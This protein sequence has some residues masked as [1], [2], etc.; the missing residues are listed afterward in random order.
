[1]LLS[2]QTWMSGSPDSAPPLWRAL[3][4]QADK[5]SDQK[6]GLVHGSQSTRPNHAFDSSACMM[7]EGADGGC[8]AYSYAC[9]GVADCHLG[10]LSLTPRR[11]PLILKMQ[12]GAQRSPPHRLA[13]WRRNPATLPSC[14]QSIVSGAGGAAPRPLWC[15]SSPSWSV[16]SFSPGPRHLTTL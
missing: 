14:I 2:H 11:C 5:K 16:Q 15:T 4:P 8:V 9:H 7:S 10:R 6:S 3:L 12:A 1:M 13:W